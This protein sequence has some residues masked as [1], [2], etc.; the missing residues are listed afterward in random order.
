M[1]MKC[2]ERLNLAEMIDRVDCELEKGHK[3][4]HQA[5]TS[6]WPNRL[7]I[8]DGKEPCVRVVLT[9]RDYHPTEKIASPIP[10]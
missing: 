7:A 4:D 8:Q 10:A 5:V 9:W 3:G 2:G 6:G 1:A